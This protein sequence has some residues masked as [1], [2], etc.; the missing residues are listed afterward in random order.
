MTRREGGSEEG[1]KKGWRGRERTLGIHGK[2]QL[3]EVPRESPGQ[4]EARDARTTGPRRED[5]E[6]PDSA[7]MLHGSP[8]A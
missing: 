3:R 8:K 2:E 7:H 5:T 6:D 4:I 1:T